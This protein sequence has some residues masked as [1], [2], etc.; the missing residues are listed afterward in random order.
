M[1][2]ITCHLSRRKQ[3]DVTAWRLSSNSDTLDPIS[4]FFS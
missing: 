1:S 2:H 3:K 4:L